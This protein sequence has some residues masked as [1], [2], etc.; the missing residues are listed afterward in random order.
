MS[1]QHQHLCTLPLL[2]P[3]EDLI[4]LVLELAGDSF[5]RLRWPRDANTCAFDLYLH[6]WMLTQQLTDKAALH[7][8]NVR[9]KGVR[10]QVNVVHFGGSSACVDMGMVLLFIIAE[11]GRSSEG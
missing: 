6:T 2:C 7:P 8:N 4:N 11:K 5:D 3:T 9:G 1:W 10:G